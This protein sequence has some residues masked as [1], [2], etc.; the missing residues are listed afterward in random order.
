VR[1]TDYRGRFVFDHYLEQE[2]MV[3]MMANF[4]VG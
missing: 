1:F 3:E 4:V 2:D